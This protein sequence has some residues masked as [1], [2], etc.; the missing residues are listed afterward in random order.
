MTNFVEI[1]PS[2]VE[3]LLFFDFSRWRPSAILDLFGAYMDHPRRVLNSPY[4]CVKIGYDR[5]SSFDNIDASIFG[6]FGWKTPIHTPQHWCFGAILP[7]K[8]AAILTKAK[9]AHP[10]VSSRHTTH[11][12]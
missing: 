8:W 3:I 12:A 10:C 2:I 11:Q 9:N 4:H 5:C 1:C 6:A 7:T